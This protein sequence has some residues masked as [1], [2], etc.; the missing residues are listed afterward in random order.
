[1]QTNPSGISSDSVLLRDVEEVD[2]PILFEQQ[3][4]LVATQMAAFTARE[5]DAFLQHWAKILKDHTGVKKTVLYEGAVAGYIVCWPESGRRLVGY[6]FGRDF[7]G[8]GIATI[9]LS[10]FLAVVPER[11]LYAYTAGHNTGSIRVLEKCGFITAQ[12]E[13]AAITEADGTSGE[14]VY[15]LTRR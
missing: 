7:W 4:D 11:P 8:K 13:E 6:W 2:L 1:M 14:L 15:V 12:H 5:R 3:C 9:A 10:Q